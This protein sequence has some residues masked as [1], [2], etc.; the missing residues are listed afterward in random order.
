VDATTI[1]S[2]TLTGGKVLLGGG[3]ESGLH[4][5]SDSGPW[6]DF[7]AELELPVSVASGSVHDLYVSMLAENTTQQR[8][9]LDYFKLRA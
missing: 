2:M 6:C 8:F 7:S 3:A 1:G 5:P 4:G 9:T